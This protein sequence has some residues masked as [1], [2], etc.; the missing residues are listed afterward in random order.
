M[1]EYCGGGGY[2]I[3]LKYRILRAISLFFARIIASISARFG[4][5]SSVRRAFTLVELLVVIAIIGILIALLLPAV[6]AARE[7]ARRMQCSNKLKQ[8]GLAIHN[9]HDATKAIPAGMSAFENH[10][11]SDRRRFSAMVKLCPY[12]ELQAV[13]DQI[14][15]KL[16]CGAFQ[17]YPSDVSGKTQDAF[18]CPT[19]TGEVPISAADNHGRNNYHVMY[20]DTITNGD[21]SRTCN[22]ST[23]SA[24]ACPR[25]FFGLRLSFKGFGGISDGL[26]NTI[27]ISERIGLQASRGQYNSTRPK[28]GTV[29]IGSSWNRDQTATR[30]Q[31]ITESQ[32]TDATPA[33][34]SA[35]IQ[36]GSGDT[37]VNGL[38]TVMAPNTASC[39]GEDWGGQ[40]VLNTPSSNHTSGINGLYGDGSVH[41]ISDTINTLTSGQSDASAIT[42]SHEEAGTS[43]W[44]VWGALGSAIGGE[45]VA[46]P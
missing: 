28:A 10:T 22:D 38:S 18:V 20:G 19:N 6:Q 16:D 5:R 40:M 39:A 46:I 1:S 37:S 26:S 23:N 9:Y 24:Y 41:F 33:G 12:I 7:A 8:L 2:A 36:W 45:S 35:G 44:G 42:K 32:K 14:A 43:I 3:W 34:N 25:G 17:N 21:N 27:A 11:H 29:K 13:Y 4:K 31:C 30:L 15:N